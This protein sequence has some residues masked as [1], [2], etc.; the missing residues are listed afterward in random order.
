MI[1]NSDNVSA[2]QNCKIK[3]AK[4][5]GELVSFP[6]FG[7]LWHSTL[8]NDGKLY[9][10]FGDGT[11]EGTCIPHVEGETHT[12]DGNQCYDTEGILL[13]KQFC[14]VYDCNACIKELCQYTSAGVVVMTGNPP[15]LVQSGEV[16]K[17]VPY[18]DARVF[19]NHDKISSLLFVNERLYAHMHYPPTKVTNGYLAYSDD[20]GR[21]WEIVPNSPWSVSSNFKTSMFVQLHDKDDYVYSMG[22]Q[23]ELNWEPLP[24][25]QQVYLNRIKE[26]L[27][28]DYSSFEYFS[29]LNE[30]EN[31]TWSKNE[32]DAVPLDGLQS[33]IIGSV[34]YHEGLD[35][36]LFLTGWDSVH[37]MSFTVTGQD[38]LEA[39][40]Y[41]AENP[42]GEWNKV[43]TFPIGEISS[44]IPKGVGQDHFYFTGAGFGDSGATYNLNIGKMQLQLE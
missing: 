6:L 2:C 13:E 37:L 28:P 7:D 11:G 19:E 3:S 17:H 21:T 39:G 18:G 14:R 22:V 29:G 9:L 40:L 43:A 27:L 10:V 30:N 4:I 35:R 42:W 26:N 44:M 1:L 41:E 24:T 15:N 16:T 23:N 8:G 32:S 36:Y 20:N 38:F 12:K 5:V 31:P 33:I 25:A 34:M